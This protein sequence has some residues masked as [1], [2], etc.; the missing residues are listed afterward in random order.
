MTTSFKALL[1][2]ILFTTLTA[3]C[4]VDVG[5]EEETIDDETN[6]ATGDVGLIEAA[7]DEYNVAVPADSEC[8]TNNCDPKI[9]GYKA[10]TLY[11]TAW[12]EKYG[13]YFIGYDALPA[14]GYDIG[15]H[16]TDDA[17][18]RRGLCRVRII[19]GSCNKN[20]PEGHVVG[21]QIGRCNPSTADCTKWANYSA[22]SALKYATNNNSPI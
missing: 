18:G 20:L 5:D 1:A 8:S 2:S 12:F 17:A 10:G 15:I 14:E 7:R 21:F 6:D 3:G 19:L 22:R 16:W 4:A 13:D 11:G 9:H